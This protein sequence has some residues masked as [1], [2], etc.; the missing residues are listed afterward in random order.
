MPESL[1]D[2]VRCEQPEPHCARTRAILQ[3]HPEIRSLFGRKNPW[4]FA[5]ILGAVACQL[6]LAWVLREQPILPVLLLAYLV[7]AFFSHTLFV[8]IHEAAHHLIF[9]RPKANLLAA[10]I[11]NL[12]TLI[13]SAL[14]FRNFHM[15]HHAFQ[16]VEELDADLPSIWEARLIGS[17][18]LGKSFWLAFFPVFQGLRT[19]RTREVAGFDFWAQLNLV[20]QAVFTLWIY[21]WMGPVALLYLLAS[22]WFSVGLHPL[23]ARWIQEH[24]L[25]LDKNQETYSYYG[26][27]NFLNLNVGYHNEHHDFPS[28]PWNLL[29][30]I[31][32]MAPEYY[33]NLKFHRSLTGLLL[34]FLFEQELS[35]FNRMVRRRPL[36]AE[37]QLRSEL[38]QPEYQPD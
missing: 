22:L 30:E 4:T 13:P 27:L 38:H 1:R 6:G 7:G 25:V 16:G 19:W 14:S 35:L 33:E 17:G 26:P 31:K 10:L 9:R 11:A 20:V 8:C 15:K 36:R 5:I 2:F 34:K 24:Y 18:F 32:R 23:G 12:P 29:P 28:V 21:H 3:A 37:R